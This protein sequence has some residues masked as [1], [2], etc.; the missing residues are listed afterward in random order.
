MTLNLED[1]TLLGRNTSLSKL[2]SSAFNKLQETLFTSNIKRPLD[3]FSDLGQI[4]IMAQAMRSDKDKSSIRVSEKL[5]S[6]LRNVFL[7]EE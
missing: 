1:M 5:E 2:H 4:G 7:G 3:A 6:A